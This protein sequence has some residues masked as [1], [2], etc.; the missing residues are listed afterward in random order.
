MQ[1]P[2]EIIEH[3]AENVFVNIP[4]FKIRKAQKTLYFKSELTARDNLLSLSRVSWEFRLAVLPYLF[5]TVAFRV[6][7]NDLHCS[8]SSGRCCRRMCDFRDFVKAT[9]AARENIKEVRILGGCLA[10]EEEPIINGVVLIAALRC[11][12][13]LRAVDIR[14]VELR[15][16]TRTK[17]M[18]DIIAQE[19]SPLHE[20][21][22]VI[23]DP[24]TEIHAI[25]IEL[26]LFAFG[27]IGR[28][29]LSGLAFRDLQ[30]YQ[31]WRPP[32]EGS[33]QPPPYYVD[34]LHLSDCMRVEKLISNVSLE[35]I[36]DL[37]LDSHVSN[38][39]DDIIDEPEGG[40]FRSVASCLKDIK[41]GMLPQEPEKY[42]SMARSHSVDLRRTAAR[43]P[44]VRSRAPRPAWRQLLQP[45]PHPC[46]PATV[47]PPRACAQADLPAPRAT[48]MVGVKS[49]EDH[50]YTWS[51][52]CCQRSSLVICSIWM[53]ASR[54]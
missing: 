50:S 4:R 38:Y 25:Q 28:V 39:E 8:S 24:Y 42:E 46:A 45:A 31:S 34:T 9:P 33:P 20:L 10:G 29:H 36:G 26:L 44:A 15:S 43:S 41:F 12:P 53:R 3:I 51:W 6:N 52:S 23:Q 48:C 21:S 37:I 40:Y 2:P 11:L 14:D 35:S 30:G 32:R 5:H 16:H 18:Q 22:Y 17:D 47:P 1:L 27:T 49:C 7:E 13:K 19:T 54:P